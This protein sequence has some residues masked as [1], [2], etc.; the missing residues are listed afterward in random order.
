MST[1]VVAEYSARMIRQ[2]IPDKAVFE[3]VEALL[4]GFDVR[5]ITSL[6]IRTAWGVRQQYGYSWWDSQ[7]IASALEAGCTTLYS[8]DLQAGRLIEGRL[9]L[10]NPFL[11]A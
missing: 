7:V 4:S 2:Q 8:E 6:T 5:E 10:V 1:Q 9:R 11:T 3:N